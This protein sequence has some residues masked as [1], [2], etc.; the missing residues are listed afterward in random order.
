MM[1]AAGW[2]AGVHDWSL[3]AGWLDGWL[4]AK[5]VVQHKILPQYDN[6]F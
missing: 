5:N 3:V 6:L 4:L 1:L 2:L